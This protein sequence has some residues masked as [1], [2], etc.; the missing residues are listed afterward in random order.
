M[1]HNKKIRLLSINDTFRDMPFV[2]FSIGDEEKI[3]NG[4]SVKISIE[5]RLDLDQQEAFAKVGSK[6]IAIGIIDKNVFRPI[7]GFNFN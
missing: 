3:R 6:L 5:D 2:D 7:R 4:V 1:V